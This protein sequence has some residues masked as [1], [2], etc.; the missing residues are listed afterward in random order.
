MA[1]DFI[2]KY[3]TPLKAEVKILLVIFAIVFVVALFDQRLATYAGRLIF[4]VI[5]F[6]SLRQALKGRKL[7]VFLGELAQTTEGRMRL[8]MAVILFA[9]AGLFFI[10]F[11]YIFWMNPREIAN[12][13]VFRFRLIVIPVG[14]IF[15]YLSYR[16]RQILKRDRV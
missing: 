10:S 15:L 9:G 8:W 4:G 16:V 12:G 6:F 7:S 3:I 2:T 14:L 5:A 13:N 11:T 1:N